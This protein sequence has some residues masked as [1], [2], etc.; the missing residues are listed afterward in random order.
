MSEGSRENKMGVWPVNKL[1]ISMSVPIMISMV[2]QAL[3]NVVDSIYIS[4]LSESA[5]TAVSLSFPV[6]QLMI[7]LNVGTGVGVNSFLSRSLGEKNYKNVNACANHGLILASISTVIFMIV[8]FTCVRP[9]FLSQTADAEIIYHGEQYLGIVCIFSFGIFHAV[10]LE[11]LLVATGRTI[12]H[13]ITQLA[14]ALTN[15]ILDPIMIF[16]LLGCPKMGA[17]GAAAATVIGQFVAFF[18][19]LFFNLTRNSDVKLGFKGFRLDFTI[20]KKIYQVGFPSILMQ[21]LGSVMTY[22]LNLILIGFTST[23]AAVLGIYFKL[24]SFV[25]MPVFG[26]NN[27]MVP[28]V[29]FNYGAKQKARI[30]K[31]IRLAITYAE[32]LMLL[33][34]GLF[35]LLTPQLLGLFDASPQ[36][37]ALGIPALRIIATHFLLAGITIVFMSVFQALGNGKYSL[38]TSLTRQIV[39]LLPVAWLFSMSG[40]VQ[41]VWWA[42]PIAEGVA[43]LL[44]LLFYRR[45]YRLR[46]NEIPG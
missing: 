39:V 38:I 24:Q 31:A 10:M 40:D 43:V 33:G 28:I 4:Y 36:M 35:I 3:Y 1:L 37:L 23:A 34:T 16:G 29:A 45:L 14:G 6:Q 17:A 19:A 46:I 26:L 18:L 5:L 21:S 13:M 44:S 7:A 2:V 20:L 8:G 22:C 27:G 41:K 15:I 30:L 25:F 9:F 12:Y 42:F 11:R 32:I